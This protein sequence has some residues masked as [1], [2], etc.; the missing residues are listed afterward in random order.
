MLKYTVEH[1][2]SGDSFLE[3]NY[4]TFILE[5]TSPL[6]GPNEY[7]VTFYCSE[8]I[9]LEEG[10][11]VSVFCEYQR[12][13]NLGEDSMGIENYNAR[14]VKVNHTNY[15]FT[16]AINKYRELR[17]FQQVRDF[18]EDNNVRYWE[19]NFVEPTVFNPSADTKEITIFY[20]HGIT[21]TFS[22]IQVVD[23]YTLLWEYDENFPDLARIVNYLFT[24]SAAGVKIYTGQFIFQENSNAE[25][26][27]TIMSLPRL[28]IVKPKMTVKIP[29]SIKED[30]DLMKEIKINEYFVENGINN[31]INPI[32]EMEKRVYSPVMFM[33]N[34][35]ID[36]SKIN[37]NLHLRE[38][39]GENWTVKE[40]DSWNCIK[41]WETY[42]DRFFPYNINNNQSD[43]LSYLNFTNKD[44]KYQKN[45]IKKSFLR[46]SY[47]DSMNDG[48]QH[49][50]GYSTVYFDV[51]KLYSKFMYTHDMPIYINKDIQTSNE[52]DIL[53]SGKV[54]NEVKRSELAKYITIENDETI[55]KYRL[56]SQISV[57]NKWA[58]DRT[59]EGFYVYLWCDNNNGIVPS[60]LYLKI[61]L[62]HAGCGR[63]I[64]L[65]AP[66]NENT[67]HFKSMIEI[68]NDWDNGNG[69]NI[70][71]YKK[72][73][74]IKMKYV[75]DKDNNRYVYYLDPER[76]GTFAGDILNINLY[77]ARISF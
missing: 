71:Q 69:Y 77:E 46:L 42:A 49:L 10:D 61:D 31:S 52:F 6:V 43:L 38:H 63:T 28:S 17:G 7:S 41:L 33:N 54:E 70:S 60:D 39:S 65:M 19:F 14:V 1:S 37:F 12:Q 16:I 26:Y 59:S 53:T 47:Y 72:F 48:D 45:V 4:D 58:S 64:P 32:T 18:T 2:K 55:E 30:V 44:V 56:S 29:I 35:F 22:D 36:V 62:N 51:A 74:Y 68:K 20:S 57:E 34:S 76:Y 67:S 9:P 75:Y 8:D 15:N 66:Y 40:N 24:N 21:T 50:L 13:Y 23:D 5:L 11:S 27:E 73:S 25:A 3:I